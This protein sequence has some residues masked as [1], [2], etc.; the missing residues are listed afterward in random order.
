MLG[1]ESVR[2]K[3]NEWLRIDAGGDGVGEKEVRFYF[4]FLKVEKHVVSCN[5]K[6]ELRPWG[7]TNKQ[8]TSESPD[9]K[10]IDQHSEWLT[11]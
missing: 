3:V 10:H 5:T 11:D 1:N 2:V 4:L 7:N 8:K 9:I 6:L